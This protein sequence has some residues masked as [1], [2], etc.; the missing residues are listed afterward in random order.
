M[1]R[2]STSDQ[3]CIYLSIVEARFLIGK[4][5]KMKVFIIVLL[6][7]CIVAHCAEI[8]MRSNDGLCT[9]RIYAR[10]G[11]AAPS[12]LSMPRCT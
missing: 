7:F 8:N 2:V 3:I 5:I 9:Y 12:I 11:I 6:L 4:T 10:A 1:Q